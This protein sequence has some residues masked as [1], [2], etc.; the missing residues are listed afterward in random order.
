MTWSCFN[1]GD[2]FLLDLGN[3][4]IQWNGPKSN[5]LERLKVFWVKHKSVHSNTAY[6]LGMPRCLNKSIYSPVVFVITWV[7]DNEV[8]S[9]EFVGQFVS[10]CLL[11]SKPLFKI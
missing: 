3:L 9:I 2:V 7:N 11:K 8:Q 10:C 1:K 6:T 5:R 4:I